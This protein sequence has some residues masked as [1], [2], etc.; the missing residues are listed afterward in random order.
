MLCHRSNEASVDEIR[1]NCQK[2]NAG[3]RCVGS[4]VGSVQA[5]EADDC[6]L[7]AFLEEHGFDV[8]VV[9]RDA[10]GQLVPPRDDD[11][12][13]AS[14]AP[15]EGVAA[16]ISSKGGPDR[17]SF[18]QLNGLQEGSETPWFLDRLDQE[19][20]PLD[21]MYTYPNAASKTTIY[22]ERRRRR[23]E[24]GLWQQCYM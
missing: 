23:D 3:F 15:G 7:E 12:T 21:S 5:I 11:V 10:A 13:A 16:S 9:E 8:H 1:Q 2:P 22:G 14:P 4:F 18:V 6:G 19:Q 17:R 20:L 24:Q